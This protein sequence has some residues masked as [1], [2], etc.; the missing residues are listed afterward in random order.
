V[1]FDAYILEDDS[2]PPGELVERNRKSRVFL[3]YPPH[4]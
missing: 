3:S 1:K 2:P 4:K